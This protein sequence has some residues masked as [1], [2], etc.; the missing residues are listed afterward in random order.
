MV[1]QTD[2]LTKTR[3]SDSICVH[4]GL[5]SELAISA[6]TQQFSNPQE[7]IIMVTRRFVFISA[8]IMVFS[9]C[10]S[11]STPTPLPPSGGGTTSI[12]VRIVYSGPVPNYTAEPAAKPVLS[13]GKIKAG[14]FST[15]FGCSKPTWEGNG[16]SWSCK[17]TLVVG[18]EYAIKIADGERGRMEGTDGWYTQSLSG[19][20]IT[21]Y[22]ADSVA[23]HVKF[24]VK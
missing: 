4:R 14:G 22:G 13:V 23:P 2:P 7:G 18:D 8:L 17:Y 6:P 1:V 24:K 20:E 19:I 10:S 16:N 9:A 5:A 21:G 11:P 3:V 15:E 12:E